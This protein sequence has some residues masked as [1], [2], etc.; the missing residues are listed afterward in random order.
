MMQKFLE[1]SIRCIDRAC[2]AGGYAAAVFMLLIVLLITVEIFLR[3][4]FH[5]STMIADEYSAYF[6]VALVMLGLGLTL[7]DGA[8]IRITLLQTRLGEK[9]AVI[10]EITAG[11]LALAL[12]SFAL[13]HSLIMVWDTF[14]LEMTADSIS[15]TPVWMPQAVIPLGFLLL[16]LQLL[17]NF[18]RR[19][20][21]YPTP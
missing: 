9:A 15:E 3:T 13:Y 7:R 8:H 19:L 5:Y 2:L 17:A 20:L 16:D 21:S 14:S 1:K 18:L 6:F 12:C 4:F 11:L 10:L